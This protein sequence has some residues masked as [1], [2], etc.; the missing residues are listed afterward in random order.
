MPDPKKLKVGDKIKFVALPEEWNVPGITL[1]AEDLAFMKKMIKRKWQ[2]RVY[3][4]SEDGYPWSRARMKK[5]G[6]FE[7]HEWGIYEKTG[8]RLVRKRLT[9]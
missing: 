4:I 7:Y 6:R 8:W 1:H 5:R 2:S 9:G 3:R